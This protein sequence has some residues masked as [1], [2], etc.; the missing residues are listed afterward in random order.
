MPRFIPVFITAIFLLSACQSMQNIRKVGTF[1]D[2]SLGSSLTVMSYNIRLGV[3]THRNTSKLYDLAWGANLPE[4]INEIRIVDPDIIGLQEVA[5]LSQARKLGVALNMN[6]AYVGHETPRSNGSWWGV[7]V[8]S[9]FP[10]LSS[11]GVE[12]SFGHGDQRT[13]IVSVLKVGRK[14]VH[15]INVHKDKDLKDGDSVERILKVVNAIKGTVILAG[16]FNF[17]PNDKYQRYELVTHQFVDTTVSIH[18]PGVLYVQKFGTFFRS[19]RRIDYIFVRPLEFTVLD[20][21][22]ARREQPASDH[23]AYFAKLRWD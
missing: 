7:A 3:G 13:I 4:I 17:T 10:I 6:Y 18:T 19:Q 2:S 16:D 20:V 9:K 1:P 12:I 11:R 15:F 14:Q 21:G 8:L 5:G 22:V 23:L